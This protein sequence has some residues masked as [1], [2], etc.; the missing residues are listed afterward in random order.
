M[1]RTV[2]SNKSTT[3]NNNETST[4]SNNSRMEEQSNYTAT[5]TNGFRWERKPNNN[6]FLSHRKIK[7][8]LQNHYER[9]CIQHLINALLLYVGNLSGLSMAVT[10]IKHTKLIAIVLLRYGKR[11]VN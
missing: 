1:N 7:S 8:T 10:D 4:K 9:Y 6:Y 2:I 5:N 3:N 11:K